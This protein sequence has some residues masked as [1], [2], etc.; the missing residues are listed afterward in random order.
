VNWNSRLLAAFAYTTLVPGLAATW[1]WFQLVNRIGTVRASTF[2]FLNPFFGV[3]IAAVL[4]NERIGMLDVMGV[5]IIMAG[6]FAVQLS[7]QATR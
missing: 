5:V 4:L 7:R 2:H 3:G 6:I 1:V